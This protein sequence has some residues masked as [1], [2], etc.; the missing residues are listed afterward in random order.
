MQLSEMAANQN[1]PLIV[2]VDFVF[3][4]DCRTYHHNI[5]PEFEQDLQLYAHQGRKIT[6]GNAELDNSTQHVFVCSL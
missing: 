2:Y 6:G 3:M 4:L 1:V 5:P